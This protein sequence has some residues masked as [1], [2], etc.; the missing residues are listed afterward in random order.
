MLGFLAGML[1]NDLAIDLG[2]ANTLV[3]ARGRNIICSEPSVVAVSE[4]G[5]GRTRRILAVGSEAKEMVGR[6]PGSIR[7]IRPIKDGVIADFEITEAML[8]YFIQRAHGRKRL[9]RP[10]IVICVPPCITSVEKRAVRESA[11]SAGAREVFLLEEPM[12]AA[13][14]AGLEV[15]E[16]T[17]NMVIDVGGGTTDVAVI[18]LA[19]IVT[20]SSVRVAG[21]KLDEAIINYVKRKHNLLI[22]E[23][24]AEIVKITIGTCMSK[25]PG[26]TMEIKGRDLVAG[27]PKMIV[28]SS[29]EVREAL[30]EPIHQIV[31]A[32]LQTL[33]RT[34]PELASDIV[35]RGIVLVGG[36]ALLRDFD[37]LLREETKL[38]I[39]RGDDP[40]TAVA[41]GAGRALES[42]DLLREVAMPD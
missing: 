36:G 26:R 39:V 42:L 33:E 22:G 40:L 10:R 27:I 2:T 13:I 23:R 31:E 1:S 35:D 9:V 12:A 20:S 38:P 30:T 11:I 41:M 16:P 17:G 25:S 4:S 28:L 34:P 18:S 8:R 6:T 37:Q 15:T 5:P 7:A 3:Y 21:D 14:G 19:G 24:T 32:V 29:D